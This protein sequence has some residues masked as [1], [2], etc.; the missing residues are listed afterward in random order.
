MGIS[1]RYNL[2]VLFLFFLQ[3]TTEGRWVVLQ[4]CH[5]AVSWLPTLEKICEEVSSLSILFLITISDAL[6][7]CER[8]A[9]CSL[10][11]IHFTLYINKIHLKR[12]ILEVEMLFILNVCVFKP[13]DIWRIEI[14]MII[15]CICVLF[16]TL[17]TEAETHPN[18]RLW[19]TSYPTNSF[20][21]SILQ[22][23]TCMSLQ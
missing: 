4:N 5:L 18:F 12:N 11:L 21:V 16:Q 17:T 13:R 1:L 23:G 2:L 6:F 22:N 19:L 9:F 3:A 14:S 8:K 20:P 7:F 15:F 10:L